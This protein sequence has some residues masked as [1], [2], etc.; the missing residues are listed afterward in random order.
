MYDV[1]CLYD[2]CIFYVI[3]CLHR[4]SI[5]TIVAGI[6]MKTKYRY[7]CTPYSTIVL[8][9]YIY[10]YQYHVELYNVNSKYSMY[11]GRDWFGCVLG[12]ECGLCDM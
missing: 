7:N 11:V 12:D 5:V 4:S 9:Q 3:D 10:L 6:H 2:I 1:Q 8:V